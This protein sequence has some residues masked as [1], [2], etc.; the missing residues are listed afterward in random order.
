VTVTVTAVNDFPVAADDADSIAEDG[1]STVDV[2]ANDSDVDGD[3]LFVLS[4]TQ[5][6]H[7]TVIDNGDGTIT[8]T[9]TRIGTVSTVTPTSCRMGP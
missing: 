3:L 8:Y 7:G 9:R 5:P 2:L 4:V 1:S 6:A